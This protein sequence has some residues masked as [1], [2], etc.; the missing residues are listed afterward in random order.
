MVPFVWAPVLVIVVRLA[1]A[2][3]V[4]RCTRASSVCFCVAFCFLWD[5]RARNRYKIPDGK[6]ENKFALDEQCMGRTYAMKVRLP[7]TKT[8][9]SL[10]VNCENR[11]A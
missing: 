10:G 6:P 1:V 4:F 2:L 9:L 11:A 5:V 8:K 3:Y 7:P